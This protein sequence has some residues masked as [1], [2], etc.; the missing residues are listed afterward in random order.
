MC[1]FCS[2]STSQ[3]KDDPQL[4]WSAVYR[5]GQA[6]EFASDGLKRDRQFVLKAIFENNT[7]PFNR[8]LDAPKWLAIQSA[9]RWHLLSHDLFGVRCDF[10]G[11]VYPRFGRDL[12]AI[13]VA[14]SL[15]LCDFKTL[16]FEVAEGFQLAIWASSTGQKKRPPDPKGESLVP[17]SVP[18]KT[19]QRV[20]A[21][22][23]SSV[24]ETPCNPG[25]TKLSPST[26]AALFSKMALTGQRTAMVD[27]VLLVFP[28]C[29]YLPQGWMEPEF[30]SED[31][32]ALWAVVVVD[33]FQLPEVSDLRGRRG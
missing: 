12:E 28:A 25:E 10:R 6:L 22:S 27:M 5:H 19:L 33:I 14:I 7:T 21:S 11:D 9:S 4:V 16:R 23:S 32:L 15:V 1:L 29:P 13:L 18:G 24:S 30:P 3:L 17:A 31:F 8:T 20:P 2:L 26:V